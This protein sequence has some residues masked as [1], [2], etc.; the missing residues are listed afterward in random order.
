MSTP[1]HDTVPTDSS[2][3]SFVIHER[4]LTDELMISHQ[5]LAMCGISTA[6]IR[7][8]SMTNQ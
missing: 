5:G 6:Y 4:V 3:I 1:L 2:V 7:L 8:L